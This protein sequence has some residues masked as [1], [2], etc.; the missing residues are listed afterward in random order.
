MACWAAL[1]VRALLTALELPINSCAC[2]ARMHVA[3]AACSAVSVTSSW[4]AGRQAWQPC[5]CSSKL[6]VPELD[7]FSCVCHMHTRV[8]AAATQRGSQAG[9]SNTRAAH[10]IVCHILAG[11][12]AGA[13]LLSASLPESVAELCLQKSRTYQAAACLCMLELLSTLLQVKRKLQGP[14]PERQAGCSSQQ[15][16]AEHLDLAQVRVACWCRSSYS[17]QSC[18]VVSRLTLERLHCRLHAGCFAEAGRRCA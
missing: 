18:S 1:Q 5:R 16:G 10:C 7:I 8:A 14:A 4:L 15:T 13:A 6:T 3:A 2:H 17:T 11:K 9:F 12:A